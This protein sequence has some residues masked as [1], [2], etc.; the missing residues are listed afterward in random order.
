VA[1]DP[2]RTWKSTKGTSV[3]A[4]LVKDA[5]ATV[6]LQKRSGQKLQV[7]RTYLSPEDRKYLDEMRQQPRTVSEEP[8]APTPRGDDR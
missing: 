7:K 3:E 8:G 1:A 4:R 6:T 2:Y 5:G